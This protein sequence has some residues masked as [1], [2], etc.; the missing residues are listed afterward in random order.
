MILMLFTLLHVCVTFSFTHL[1]FLSGL[2][3]R[4]L[5]VLEGVVSGP[6]RTGLMS[7][8]GAAGSQSNT[9][10][11]PQSLAV[12]SSF[13]FS[14]CLWLLAKKCIPLNLTYTWSTRKSEQKPLSTCYRALPQ[15][16]EA[17]Q[18]PKWVKIRVFTLIIQNANIKLSIHTHKNKTVYFCVWSKTL[19]D[20]FAYNV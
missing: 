2:A 13:Q 10:W 5:A 17:N 16:T 9:P 20:G 19:I 14:E 1:V 8:L 18:N 7:A 6:V 15:M 11:L 3:D 4:R 12:I